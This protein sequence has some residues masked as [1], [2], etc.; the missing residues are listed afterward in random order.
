[1]TSLIPTSQMDALSGFNLENQP[2][3]LRYGEEVQHGLTNDQIKA[4]LQRDNCVGEIYQFISDSLTMNKL[5]C[6]FFD[7]G[8][9]WS[10]GWEL[11]RPRNEYHTNNSLIAVWQSEKTIVHNIDGFPDYKVWYY[12]IFTFVTDGDNK[13]INFKNNFGD[14]NQLKLDRT[15]GC[16]QPSEM[17]IQESCGTYCCKTFMNNG[18]IHCRSCRQLE[19]RDLFYLVP[20][21][22]SFAKI[23]NA[24]ILSYVKVRENID[25][26]VE[27]DVDEQLMLVNQ[28]QKTMAAIIAARSS[29]GQYEQELTD[30]I[31]KLDK[32]KN[33][34]Q[35][36]YINLSNKYGGKIDIV[37][38]HIEGKKQ[39]IVDA[40]ATVKREEQQ[41]KEHAETQAKL[42]RL[43]E[44][45]I[46]RQELDQ[47]I[48][49]MKASL[50][51]SVG[52]SGQ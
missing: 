11:S 51:S 38:R 12:V 7:Q 31:A 27:K 46:R 5:G 29:G 26:N 20:T 10:A 52:K 13:P 36:L 32:K 22:V 33:D 49:V 43:Q 15:I 40:R 44:L 39:I 41:R 45:E 34:D 30:F 6:S 19:A 24:N 9:I 42:R 47:A 17:Q 28:D 16:T 50:P 37:Q 1:M 18:K 14:F 23:M 35:Q 8:I 48:M 21:K 4:E 25:L 2:M 3:A